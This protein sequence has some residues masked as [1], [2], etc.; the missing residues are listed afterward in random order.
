MESPCWAGRTLSSKLGSASTFFER[1]VNG[2]GADLERAADATDRDPLFQ[3]AQDGRFLLGSDRA[4]DRIEGKGLVTGFA[5]RSLGTRFCSAELDDVFGLLTV[6]AG[7][8]N[9]ASVV[10]QN[11]PSDKQG[12]L[13]D[14]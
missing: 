10:A 8:S 13:Q 6:R 4:A 12:K 2:I 5:A 14:L 11:S 3:L 1:G 9:H 7:N